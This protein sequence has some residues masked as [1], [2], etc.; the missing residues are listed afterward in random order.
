MEKLNILLVCGGGASSG[1]L[2]NNMRK[3]ANKRNLV[4]DIMAKS[5]TA[6]D[7]YKDE[8]D[9]LLLGPH[10]KYMEKEVRDNLAGTA[11]KITVVDEAI[12]SALDGEAAVDMVLKLIEEQA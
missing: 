7:D 3:A 6:I 5:E 1:F 4:M 11:V 10:L 12:Y 2:A 9:V 8:I